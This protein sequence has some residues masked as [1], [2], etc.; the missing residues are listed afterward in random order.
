MDP[1]VGDGHVFWTKGGQLDLPVG[2]VTFFGPKEVSWISLL[3]HFIREVDGKKSQLWTSPGRW[4]SK[5]ANHASAVYA[6][7]FLVMEGPSPPL[8]LPEFLVR[9]YR[10]LIKSESA[11]SVQTWHFP[12]L[13]LTDILRSG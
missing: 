3:V 2:D 6:F 13:V 1:R 12:R 9:Y 10:N 8:I 11:F 7:L 5:S 4:I